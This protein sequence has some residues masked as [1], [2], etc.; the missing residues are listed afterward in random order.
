[1]TNAIELSVKTRETEVNLNMKSAS[2]EDRTHLF[3]LIEGLLNS[4]TTVVTTSGPLSTLKIDP[5]KAKTAPV[6]SQSTVTGTVT[7]KTP[8]AMT[9]IQNNVPVLT[10]SAG[11][12]PNLYGKPITSKQL[13]LGDSDRTPMVSVGAK[14]QAA[15]ANAGEP[16]WYK[17]GIKIMD[18]GEKRYKCRFECECGRKGNH[19]IEK[20]ALEVPCFDC[21]AP[22]EVQLAT[23]IVDARGIPERDGWG[24]YYVAYNFEEEGE[25]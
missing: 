2:Q 20:G 24:N 6:G 7:V 22:L 4:E 10:A 13:P 21:N 8:A 14:L 18:D 1:M 17:T 19:Y 12:T 15:V 25:D 3:D 23:G 9:T 11:V 16:E 5:T